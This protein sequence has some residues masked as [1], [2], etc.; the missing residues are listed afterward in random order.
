MKANVYIV[1]LETVFRFEIKDPKRGTYSEVQPI[2]ETNDA[3]ECA[4]W[5]EGMAKRIRDAASAQL[6]KETK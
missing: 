2:P 1:E 5:I 3:F 6:A 4:R